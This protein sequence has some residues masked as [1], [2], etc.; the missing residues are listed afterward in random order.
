VVFVGIFNRLRFAGRAT[1]QNTNKP[2]DLAW[3][4]DR[5]VPGQW[6]GWWRCSR[7]DATV[8]GNLSY[9]D[10]EMTELKI[11]RAERGRQ[12]AEHS[13]GL[14]ERELCLVEVL[15]GRSPWEAALRV[16]GARPGCLSKGFLPLCK[17]RLRHGRRTEWAMEKLPAELKRGRSCERWK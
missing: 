14:Q 11:P 9:S 1:W 12:V 2:G 5:L 17:T 4:R 16:T 15:L 7:S 10:H 13:L 6:T 8:S 3:V